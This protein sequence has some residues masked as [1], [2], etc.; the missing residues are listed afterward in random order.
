KHE[1]FAA[2]TFRATES[3]KPETHF[4]YFDWLLKE[5]EVGK[6]RPK[7]DSRMM[8]FYDHN[9]HF[10]RRLREWSERSQSNKD[11]FQNISSTCNAGV[12]LAINDVTEEKWI[13][14]V[15]E[16]LFPGAQAQQKSRSIAI[17]SA[18]ALRKS[19][20]RITE[21][22]ALENAVNDIVGHLDAPP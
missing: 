15:C 8:V 6:K 10:R 20:L 13:D 14:L 17:I 7:S 22:A 4:A 1:Q 11:R 16:L 3:D 19:G 5:F 18:D 21:F 12:V 9:A 2:E